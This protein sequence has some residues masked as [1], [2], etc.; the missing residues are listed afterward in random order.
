MSSFWVRKREAA[1]LSLLVS[2]EGFSMFSKHVSETFFEVKEVAFLLFSIKM[3][4]TMV[5]WWGCSFEL[6]FINFLKLL[7]FVFVTLYMTTPRSLFLTGSCCFRVHFLWTKLRLPF[8]HVLCSTFINVKFVLA[9]Y[10]PVIQ[11]HRL[12]LD[13]W[14]SSLLAWVRV[15]YHT[16]SHNEPKM[17]LAAEAPVWW[18]NLSWCWHGDPNIAAR[19][20]PR[21]PSPSKIKL[22]TKIICDI[23]K[24][25]AQRCGSTQLA[26]CF[27]CVL[28]G[29][30]NKPIHGC[31]NTGW[32]LLQSLHF[33][34]V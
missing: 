3:S 33:L 22:T 19:V 1:A 32:R 21:T 25:L 10:F 6:N 12:A 15:P 7:S 14:V 8:F 9:P 31:W 5:A 34:L 20:Q 17:Y 27:C 11:A 28:L 29:D 13:S 2:L 23:S 16:I 26:Q 4:S 30:T 24:N 18:R